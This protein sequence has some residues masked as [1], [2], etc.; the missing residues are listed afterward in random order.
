ME[1]LLDVKNNFNFFY[2]S[3][4]LLLLCI[5][6]YMYMICFGNL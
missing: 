5:K 4:L 3:I 1:Y 2:G 6:V